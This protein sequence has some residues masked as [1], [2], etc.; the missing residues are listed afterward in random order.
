MLRW[1]IATHG[2]YADPCGIAR[3]LGRGAA[4]EPVLLELGR[5]GSRIPDWRVGQIGLWTR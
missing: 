3:A 1:V 5:W 2:S 4:L